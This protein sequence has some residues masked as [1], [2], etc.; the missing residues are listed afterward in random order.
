[1]TDHKYKAVFTY[2]SYSYKE[3]FKRARKALDTF[4]YDREEFYVDIKPDL[5][6]ISFNKLDYIG[7]S[8]IARQITKAFIAVKGSYDVIEDGHI[9]M[10]GIAFEKLA[11]E[12]RGPKGETGEE[13]EDE[14]EEEEEEE[15]WE[16]EDEASET[17]DDEESD[18]DSDEEEYTYSSSKPKNVEEVEGA[19]YALFS[20][21]DYRKEN[22]VNFVGVFANKQV[23]I[24]RI[25][26]I[27]AGKN[28]MD[29]RWQTY[30]TPRKFR[31]ENIPV[32]IDGRQVN[33]DNLYVCLPDTNKPWPFEDVV[34]YDNPWRIEALIGDKQS[35]IPQFE[36]EFG[37]KFE[38]G[39]TYNDMYEYHGKDFGIT[40]KEDKGEAVL[41]L[42]SLV[43]DKE[44]VISMVKRFFKCFKTVY[45]GTSSEKI[46]K[47]WIKNINE[48]KFINF[49]SQFM[50]TTN[51]TIYIVQPIT[52]Q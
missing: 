11:D 23:A 19:L 28:M 46:C 42:R 3:G 22:S 34:R 27:E 25:T 32:Y 45:G 43:I 10:Y 35:P 44:N 18:E 4:P 31:F 15:T 33:T 20:T 40:F 37:I 2:L 16:E 36:K 41:Y 47:Y 29:K 13:E 8:D 52:P 6:S 26:Q 5:I 12:L 51:G 7:V 14:E 38:K 48:E 17:G 39:C 21:S 49:N 1:M 24:D 50:D 30:R 9:I